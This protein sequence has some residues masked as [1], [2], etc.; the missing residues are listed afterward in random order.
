MLARARVCG[1][2]G[3]RESGTGRAALAASA[4]SG[5]TSW[6]FVSTGWL[7]YFDS[8]CVLGM[9]VAAFGRSKV[10][11]GLACLLTPWVDERFVL[12]LPLVVVVRGICASVINGKS[13]ARFL[14]EG[15]RCC[16]PWRL[17][18]IRLIALAT[19]QDEASAAHL[20]DHLASIH[21]LGEVADGLWSGLRGLWVFVAV[22][23]AVLFSKG[24]ALRATLLL[25]AVL[26]PR[27]QRMCRW[28]TIFQPH[29]VD[30]D[31]GGGAGDDPAG[32]GASLDGGM[33][34][35]GGPR[36]QPS[37]AGPSYHRG[38]G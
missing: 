24:L 14:S 38:L 3:A 34:A 23:P 31:A 12:T 19:T 20:R 36:V 11:T 13:S 32:A 7:A 9:L 8:W 33:A 2:P 16:L 29:D 27:S 1:A 28:P 30:D 26:W 15:L 18:A 4:L 37:D 17:F 35:F 5:T 22:G 25:M 21:N 10:A 6:F